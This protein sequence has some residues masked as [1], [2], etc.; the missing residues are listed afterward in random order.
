[1]VLKMKVGEMM[2]KIVYE[3]GRD[4]V[5]NSIYWCFDGASE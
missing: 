4:D 1:M 3:N 5:E 2:L